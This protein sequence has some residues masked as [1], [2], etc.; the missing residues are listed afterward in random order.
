[1][2]LCSA[3]RATFARMWFQK[4]L[5]IFN[6][7]VQIYTGGPGLIDLMFLH[8][9]GIAIGPKDDIFFFKIWLKFSW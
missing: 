6:T 5:F 8:G 4:L 7:Q 2:N 3:E 1:M 9:I